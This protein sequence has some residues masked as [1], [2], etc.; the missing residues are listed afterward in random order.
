MLRV[1]ES[2]S[3]KKEKLNFKGVFFHRFGITSET[4]RWETENLP[5]CRAQQI[6]RLGVN[7]ISSKQT[8]IFFSLF[9]HYFLL[10]RF[11]GINWVTIVVF[12]NSVRLWCPEVTH[13]LVQ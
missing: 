6:E 11:T 1:S 2:F 12:Y 9:F 8:K 13:F 4:R 10:P 7:L 3:K 5:N